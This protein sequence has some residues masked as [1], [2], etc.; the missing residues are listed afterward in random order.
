M[1]TQFHIGQQIVC[2]DDCWR[3]PFRHLV[4]H[5]PVAGRIYTIREFDADSPG[6][7]IFL[8]LEEI[9]NPPGHEVS[10]ASHCFR[11]VKKT[12]ISVF[13]VEQRP[14]PKKLRAPSPRVLED[15]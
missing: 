4:P 3:H 13:M 7:C 1:N 10:F 5:L 8:W 6:Y 2:I 15:A 9:V 14:R 12:D 11:P